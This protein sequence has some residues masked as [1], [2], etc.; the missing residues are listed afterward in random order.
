MNCVGGG[1][2]VGGNSGFTEVR[3]TKLPLARYHAIKLF[4]NTVLA[5]CIIKF[6]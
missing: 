1:R 2:C 3:Q 4:I 6:D 5:V